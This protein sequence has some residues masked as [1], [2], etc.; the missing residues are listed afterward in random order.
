MDS[1]GWL[2]HLKSLQEKVEHHLADEE[3]EFFFKLLADF[4]TIL[5]RVNLP[6]LTKKKWQKN[7]RL[8]RRA[9]HIN[10]TDT[11]KASHRLAFLFMLGLLKI[12][13]INYRLAIMYTA[14]ITPGK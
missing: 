12:S 2:R 5:K 14:W 8:T 10:L 9:F 11:K 3:Q 1:P 4:L 13:K 6:T 7:S